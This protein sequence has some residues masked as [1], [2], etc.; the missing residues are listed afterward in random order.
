MAELAQMIV[1][2]S[3]EPERGFARVMLSGVSN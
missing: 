3:P 2:D 1:A